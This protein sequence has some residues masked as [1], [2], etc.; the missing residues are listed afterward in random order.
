VNMQSRLWAAAVMSDEEQ[1]ELERKANMLKIKLAQTSDCVK[2]WGMTTGLERM[3]EF[4]Q[5]NKKWHAEKPANE[6]LIFLGLLPVAILFMSLVFCAS[7]VRISRRH[8]DSAHA[9]VHH[10]FP[11]THGV[12]CN[13]L[14]SIIDTVFGMSGRSISVTRSPPTVISMQ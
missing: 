9:G 7:L 13:F 11:I 8:S 10:S 1:E 2:E 4:E 6:K 12:C 5:N 14:S 3:A